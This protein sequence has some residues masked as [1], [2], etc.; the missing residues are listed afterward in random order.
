MKYALYVNNE[1]V[2]S[3]TNKNE[4]MA[5]GVEVLTNEWNAHTSKESDKVTADYLDMVCEF[6]YKSRNRSGSDF[7]A[8]CYFND[9]YIEVKPFN[10]TVYEVIYKISSEKGASSNEDYFQ[11]EHRVLCYEDKVDK[12]IKQFRNKLERDVENELSLRGESF[13]DMLGNEVECLQDERACYDVFNTIHK[14][15]HTIVVNEV[16]M[17]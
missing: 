5:R 2:F 13:D 4:C 9:K 8:E 15:F 6:T 11:L 1:V 16:K 10:E 17:N 14:K 3:S 12:I 7:Y